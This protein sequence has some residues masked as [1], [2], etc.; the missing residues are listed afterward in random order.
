MSKTTQAMPWEI[1]RS[2]T[3]QEF[4]FP[5]GYILRWGT[6]Y[7]VDEQFATLGEAEAARKR[8][9]FTKDGNRTAGDIRALIADLDFR[10]AVTESEAERVA[11]SNAALEARGFDPVSAEQRAQNV[12]EITDHFCKGGSIY[13]ES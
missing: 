4:K 6:T 7:A 1:V 9:G 12:R 5:N 2:G 13:G 10:A 11:E 8:N 3:S